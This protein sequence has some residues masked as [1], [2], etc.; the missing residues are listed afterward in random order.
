MIVTKDLIYPFFIYTTLLAWLFL[1]IFSVLFL[2]KKSRKIILTFVRKWGFRLIF[3]IS[4]LAMVGSLSFSEI[5]GWLPCKLCWYQRIFIYPQVFIS[6]LAAKIKDK[7]AYIYHFLLSFLGFWFAFFHY[8]I[9]RGVIKG[10]DCNLVTPSGSCLFQ[11][12]FA[13]GFISIPFMAMT[14]FLM[15]LLV[16]FLN[17]KISFFSRRLD[18]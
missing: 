2:L 12:N 14:A 11:I 3:F 17:F 9:Q 5:L 10:I 6:L 4:F 1:L 8:L 18:N 13:F 15:I 7:K 16:S